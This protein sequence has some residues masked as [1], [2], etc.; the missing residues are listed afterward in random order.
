MNFLLNPRPMSNLN[1]SLN[2]L[3][4]LEIPKG[5]VKKLVP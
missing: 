2:H 5:F 4:H 1:K 3:T